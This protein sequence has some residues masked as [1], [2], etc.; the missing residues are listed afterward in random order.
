MIGGIAEGRKPVGTNLLLGGKV[1]KGVHP[2]RVRTVPDVIEGGAALPGGPDLPGGVLRLRQAV[3]TQ[4]FVSGLQ[5]ER[6][7]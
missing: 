2:E 7:C 5:A 4:F 1:Q 3:L 6:R